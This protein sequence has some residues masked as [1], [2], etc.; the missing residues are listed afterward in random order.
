VIRGEGDPVDHSVE[1]AVA[2]GVQGRWPVIDVGGQPPH[3]VGLRTQ[4][5]VTA[6]EHGQIDADFD[7]SPGGG[8]ADDSGATDEEDFK[9]CHGAMT[10]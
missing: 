4:R 8:C 9:G 5:R 7:R 2:Q 10:S 6:S 3:T 1:G